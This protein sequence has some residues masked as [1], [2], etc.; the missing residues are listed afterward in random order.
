MAEQ[1]LQ[2]LIEPLFG[3]LDTMKDNIIK[4][5]EQA[6]QRAS[7]RTYRN[8]YAEVREESQ[9]LRGDIYAPAYFYTLI[10]GRGPGKIP[11]NLPQILLDWVKNKGLSFGNQKEMIKFANATAWKIRKEGSELYRNYL[12]VDLVGTPQRIFEESMQ[13]L[14]N[15]W[16]QGLLEASYHDTSV[17]ESSNYANN[18]HGY[19]I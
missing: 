19:I 8:M 12:Y 5:S 13:E 1:S 10:R 11:A 4:Q 3:L 2:S 6:G 16:M 17:P 14:I 18:Y 7:G 15:V 9:T